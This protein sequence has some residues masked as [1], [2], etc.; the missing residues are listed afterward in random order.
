[1]RFHAKQYLAALML[2]ANMMKGLIDEVKKD[3]FLFRIR[4]MVLV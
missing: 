4:L 3:I 1:M 2:S